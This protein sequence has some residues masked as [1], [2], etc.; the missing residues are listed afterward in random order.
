MSI[1]SRVFGYRDTGANNKS[2]SVVEVLVE[3]QCSLE[4]DNLANTSGVIAGLVELKNS[5]GRVC[6]VQV[7]LLGDRLSRE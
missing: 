7:V 2:S 1:F 4:G 5:W 3:E 6:I